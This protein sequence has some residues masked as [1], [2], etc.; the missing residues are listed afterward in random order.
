MT[1]MIRDYMSPDPVALDKNA[2]LLDA[3]RA[4]RDNDVG[5]VL[6]TDKGRLFGI[7]T[8]RDIVVRGVAKGLDSAETPVEAI[9]SRDIES[10]T[11][12]H[13]LREAVEL[14]SK[15]SVRRVPIARDGQPLGVLAVGDVVA[16]L[17]P[18]SPLGQV[19]SAPP[20]R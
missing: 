12:E 3:A 2:T 20:N 13:S 9:C 15:H 11:P 18:D 8:D 4:M 17:N 6:V 16:A 19:S 14:M 10:L 1:R 5:N 7:L